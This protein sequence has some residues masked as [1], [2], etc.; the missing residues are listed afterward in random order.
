MALGA[1]GVNPE[2]EV[3]AC[4]DASEGGGFGEE[5]FESATVRLGLAPGAFDSPLCV[6]AH[7]L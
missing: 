1:Q 5:T 4:E 3:L 7:R 6:L 2:F